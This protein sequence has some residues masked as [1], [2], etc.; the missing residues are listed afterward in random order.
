MEG[1][2]VWFIGFIA[3]IVFIIGAWYFIQHQCPSCLKRGAYYMHAKKNGDRDR[4]Y[5]INPLICPSCGYNSHR[6]QMEAVRTV[7]APVPLNVPL[8]KPLKITASI[9]K[10][11]PKAKPPSEEEVF[12]EWLEKLE[13]AL[14]AYRKKVLQDALAVIARPDLRQNLILGASVLDVA[15]VLSK[16]ANLKT[17]AAKKRHLEATL[18]Q[19]RNDELP[20]ELQAKEIEQLDGILKEIIEAE[21]QAPKRPARRAKPDKAD[22]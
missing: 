17:N 12:D 8:I 13:K 18:E 10:P 2:I 1:P 11:E 21:S 7:R 15:D 5:N 6:A 22:S 19:L 16:V 3:F 20:D 4:R 9:A 14:G